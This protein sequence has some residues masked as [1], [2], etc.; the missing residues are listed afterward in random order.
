MPD[1]KPDIKPD[2]F[3]PD[4]LDTQTKIF[5]DDNYQSWVDDLP[6][7]KSDVFLPTA[8]DNLDDD[9]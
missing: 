9:N 4:N 3:L 2:V 7:I 8:D 6:D 1:I 5:V